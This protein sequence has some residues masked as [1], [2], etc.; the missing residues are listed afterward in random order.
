M[1][2]IF[3]DIFPMITFDH[4]TNTS[5]IFLPSKEPISSALKRSKS[6]KQTEY[7]SIWIRMGKRRHYYLPQWNICNNNTY[8]YSRYRSFQNTLIALYIGMFIPCNAVRLTVEC[9]ANNKLAR[10]KRRSRP[11]F[12]NEYLSIDMIPIVLN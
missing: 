12:L 10:K 2:S 5:E 3:L 7:I 4:C 11:P 9:N 8:Y 6:M 1:G